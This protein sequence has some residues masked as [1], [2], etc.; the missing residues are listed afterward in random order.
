MI[1]NIFRS[2]LDKITN[3]LTRRYILGHLQIDTMD[4]VRQFNERGEAVVCLGCKKVMAKRDA[5]LVYDNK[6]KLLMFLH[7]EC[8]EDCFEVEG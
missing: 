1:K 6:E 7:K 4:A 5:V 3:E 8:V 2:I